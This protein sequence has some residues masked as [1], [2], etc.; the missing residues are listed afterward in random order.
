MQAFV[1]PSPR[2]A[3]IKQTTPFAPSSAIQLLVYDDPR[4]E[5]SV[6]IVWVDP[7]GL[8]KVAE[9]VL[10]ASGGGAK[11]IPARYRRRF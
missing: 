3:D 8:A 5:F 11:Y 1:S 9:Q 2:L 10:H 4:R 7:F 6:G